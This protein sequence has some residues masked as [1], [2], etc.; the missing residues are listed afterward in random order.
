LQPKGLL[1]FLKLEGFVHNLS[2]Y[3]ENKIAITKLEYKQKLAD[4]LAAVVVLLPVAILGLIAFLFLNVGLAMGINVWLDSR[5]WGFV[6]VGGFYLIIAV[7]LFTQ[8]DAAWV[9]K[10]FVDG[11]T[12]F[13]KE[14]VKPAKKPDSQEP[15]FDA[16]EIDHKKIIFEDEPVVNGAAKPNG[17]AV[18]TSD[19][20]EPVANSTYG[21]PATQSERPIKEPKMAADIERYKQRENA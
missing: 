13:L 21:G 20:Y 4:A 18:V 11:T 8:R 10:I 1:K 12:K 17:S 3:I 5:A 2:E 6:I 15:T 7:V 9:K 19:T 14:K 16:P